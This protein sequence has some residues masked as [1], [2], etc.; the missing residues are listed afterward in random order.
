MQERQK[1]SFLS[2]KLASKMID[3]E[4]N[5]PT[6]SRI[7][8]DDITTFVPTTLKLME[9][10]EDLRVLQETSTTTDNTNES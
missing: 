5:T 4:A 7:P 8:S 10:L 1:P 2:E 3:S 6:R 9:K